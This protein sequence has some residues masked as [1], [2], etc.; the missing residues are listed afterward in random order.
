MKQNTLCRLRNRKLLTVSAISKQL[1]IAVLSLILLVPQVA[2][3]ESSIPDPTQ[4]ATVKVSGRVLDDMG[5]PL[6]GATLQLIGSSKGVITDNDGTYTFNDVPVG[7]EISVSF[8]GM[9]PQ[10]FKV[11]GP[12]KKDIPLGMKADEL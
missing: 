12:M 10:K 7:S 5:M 2:L 11:T 6:P 1:I 3:A 4:G 9:E 8:I